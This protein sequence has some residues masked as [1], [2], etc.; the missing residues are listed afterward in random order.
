MLIL[1][2]GK[3]EMVMVASENEFTYI[4]AGAGSAGCVLA[5][6]L[7]EDPKNRVLLLEA[8]TKDSYPWIHIPVGYF[9]TAMNP[10]TDWCFETEADPGLNGRSIP[11]PRGKVLGGSSSINGLVYVRGQSQDYDQWRQL[12]N[13]GW[14]WDEVLPYFKKAEDQQRGESETHG[15]GGPL[16]VSDISFTR[17]FSSSFIDAAE[18]VG[19]PRTD[20]FNGGDQEGVGFYQLTTRNGRRCSAAVGFL[21]PVKHR[22]N[23]TIATEALVHRVIFEGKR[24]VGVEFSVKGEKRVERVTKQG[25]EILLSCGAIASPKVLQL[26]GVG[27]ASVMQEFGIDMVH[28]LPGVG[29]NLQDHLAARSV[30]KTN[31][32][33]LNNEVNSILGKLRIGLEYA[34]FRK[35]PLTIAA[36]HVGMFAK[37]RP[38][39]ETPDVQ[40]HVI[41]LSITGVGKELHR[42]AAFTASVCQL[43]PE[44]RGH[45]VIKSTDPSVDPG[46]HPNYLATVNDQQTIV[47]GLKLSRKIIATPTMQKLVTE[48][49][50][51][52]LA[53]QTDEQLLQFARDTGSTVYHP[54]ST[55]KMGPDPMA[56]VDERLRVHGMWGLRV[57]DA[58]IMP[59]LNSGNTNA[60]T[61]MIG[62]KA[63]DMILE[64]ARNAA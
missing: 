22:S 32:P 13:A 45:V 61:I 25:G 36:G 59:T 28:E 18:E 33:S 39:L 63:A 26:S 8:G 7:S 24:A 12:G 50:A 56:V 47:D 5:N 29:M 42:F 4:I 1:L 27:P 58:S 2:I 30:Y 11:Y 20:D 43:R 37:T 44:S 35:G 23:L 34:L 48:E 41:P 9:K 31:E 21:N 55:C 3:G 40:F 16:V 17:G 52:G 60:P 38:D 62:E 15:V 64:D 54:V 10:K 53:T 19:I 6:R 57:V 49:F 51:P 14:S 46:I